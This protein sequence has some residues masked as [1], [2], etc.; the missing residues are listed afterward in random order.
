M[1]PVSGMTPAYIGEDSAKLTTPV[2]LLM[3][4][5]HFC[6]VLGHHVLHPR[7]DWSHMHPQA[8]VQ[9]KETTVIGMVSI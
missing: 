1:K 4:T 2:V 5:M 7:P 3:N 6:M 9:L 8:N